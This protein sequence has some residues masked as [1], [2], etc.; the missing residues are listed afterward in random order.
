MARRRT[1]IKSQVFPLETSGRDDKFKFALAALFDVLGE[2][3]VDEY[4]LPLKLEITFHRK[5]WDG[6]I[7]A[8][9]SGLLLPKRGRGYGD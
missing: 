2:R 9:L 4:S 3:I 6:W 7:E 5:D 8:S 1:V